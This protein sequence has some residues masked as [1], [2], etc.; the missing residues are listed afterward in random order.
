MSLRVLVG[1]AVY[2]ED[3]RSF[4]ALLKHAQRQAQ[5]HDSRRM[6]VA[7]IFGRRDGHDLPDNFFLV[8]ALN[9]AIALNQL[10]LQ[11]QPIVDASTGRTV[12]AEALLRWR[13]PDLG[14][15]SPGVFIPLAEKYGLIRQLSHWVL[16]QALQDLA[17]WTGLFGMDFQVSVNRSSHDLVDVDESVA[18]VRDA[19]HEFGLCGSNLVVEI[20]EHSLVSS[21]QTAE[22][23][24]QAYRGMGIGIAMDDFGTGYSSLSYLRQYPVSYLKIDKSFIDRLATDGLDQQL[25]EG[26]V[27]IGRRLGMRVVAEGVE[28]PIQAELLRSMGTEY[29]QGYHFSRPLD[30]HVLE[31]RLASEANTAQP[32]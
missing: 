18:E 6:E 14:L 12:K 25:C 26:I 23:I 1:V 24:L 10:H 5:M 32:G 31:A 22:R 19:L 20:T 2:P 15:V 7:P 27:D 11:Y 28:T 8:Q 29:L 17:R 4:N 21:S 30:A 16:R 3:G 9:K 13:H